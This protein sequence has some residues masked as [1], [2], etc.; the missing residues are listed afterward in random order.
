MKPSEILFSPAQFQS[1]S[2]EWGKLLLMLDEM[3]EDIT[4]M[5]NQVKNPSPFH[6]SFYKREWEE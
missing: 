4:E 3:A 1:D 2:N 6:E 5:K